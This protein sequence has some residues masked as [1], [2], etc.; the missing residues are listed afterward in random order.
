MLRYF[1]LAQSGG[2]NVAIPVAILVAKN[3]EAKLEE[4]CMEMQFH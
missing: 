3:R 4:I 2:S 1:S